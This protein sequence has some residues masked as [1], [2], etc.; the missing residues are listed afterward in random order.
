MA[1][2]Q[3]TSGNASRVTYIYISVDVTGEFL[4]KFDSVR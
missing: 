3:H 1:L 2:K 4:K